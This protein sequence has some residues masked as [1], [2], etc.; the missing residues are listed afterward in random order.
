MLYDKTILDG[1]WG[2]MV[3]LTRP[4]N[5]LF[6][7]ILLGLMERYVAEPVL[8]TMVAQP[9][10]SWYEQLL[11]IA[12]V[13]LIAA[14]GYVV[15]AYFDVKIDSINHPDDLVVTRDVT[16]KEAMTFFQVLTA[17]G[18]SC[19]L[20]VSVLLK[21]KLLGVIF[22]L[23]PGLLWFY[24]ASYKRQFL[25]GNLIIAL[26]AGVSPL[27]IAFANM[28]KLNIAFGADCTLTL[29]LTA[30]LMYWM[31]GFALFSFLTTWIRE[32]VKDLEDQ[33]G[34]REL[35]CHT[36]PVKYGDVV[37]K[38]FV[39]LLVVGT[40]ALLSWVYFRGLQI[41]F[42][43]GNTV[44]RFYLLLMLVPLCELGLLWTAKIPSDYRHAQL[45]M[46]FWMFMGT[47]F[48][49]CVPSLLLL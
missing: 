16:K 9:R 48:A 26:L 2:G 46:K 25:V 10:L 28:A 41:P 47:M 8:G 30:R 6:L 24:S 12:A 15:N 14:G 11:L 45:L 23:T 36:F 19:G 27:I 43:W 21:S 17:A 1:K 33:E 44:S 7:I 35:E 29:M 42:A 18:V 37:T 13:V 31:G 20:A 4:F 5:W 32:V 3:K 34:D 49:F 38:V 39:S 22:I 40:M